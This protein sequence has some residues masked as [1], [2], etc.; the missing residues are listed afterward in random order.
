[1]VASLAIAARCDPLRLLDCLYEQPDVFDSIWFAAFPP[2]REKA[3]G[4][5][6]SDIDDILGR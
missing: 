2:R 1:M 5:P 4:R 6:R 3:D